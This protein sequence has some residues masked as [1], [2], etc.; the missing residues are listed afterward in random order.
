MPQC[1]PDSG[2]GRQEKPRLPYLPGLSLRPRFVCFRGSAPSTPT[3]PL[4]FPVCSRTP[5]E[6]LGGWGGG[7]RRVGFL[8]FLL[9]STVYSLP[10]SEGRWG[11]QLGVIGRWGWLGNLFS[12]FSLLASPF[13]WRR[14]EG[15]SEWSV[16][17]AGELVLPPTTT[18]SRG[19]GSSNSS[20]NPTMF[21]AQFGFSYRT[22]G[23]TR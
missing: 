14:G 16:V 10:L 13:L 6:S 21:A 17:L 4:G 3:H 8:P 2:P 19:R 12:P 22:P 18:Q 11:K 15:E 5:Q 9:P 23:R 1:Q 20:P 7:G